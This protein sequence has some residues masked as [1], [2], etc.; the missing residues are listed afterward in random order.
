[1]SS[2]CHGHGQQSQS[3]LSA[4]PAAHPSPA[5]AAGAAAS[6]RP[7]APPVAAAAAGVC[8][9]AAAAR[10][11]AQP[12]QQLQQRRLRLHLCHAQAA[13]PPR[14]AQ[15]GQVATRPTGRLVPAPPPVRCS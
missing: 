7:G 2:A 8:P 15:A 13:R 11:Q 6:R 4:R 1:M 10:L 5:P 12:W 3:C 9:A 14:A